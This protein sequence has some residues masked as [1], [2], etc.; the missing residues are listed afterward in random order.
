V[1]ISRDAYNGPL[2]LQSLAQVAV[3]TGDN[4]RATETIRS[5]LKYPGY[6]SYGYLLKDPA[7]A[8]LKDDPE[9]QALIQTQLSSSP[10]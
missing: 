3:W 9:F 7:W 5:L 2:N 8:P 10:R 1:P 4:S 6:L